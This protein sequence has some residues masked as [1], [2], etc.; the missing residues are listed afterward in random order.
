MLRTLLPRSGTARAAAV[1]AARGAPPSGPGD[2]LWSAQGPAGH[3]IA[4]ANG[5]QLGSR[6]R[7]LCG[8][9]GHSDFNDRLVE[10]SKKAGASGAA[11]A[12][13]AGNGGVKASVQG[14]VKGA[15]KAGAA[16]A[17]AAAA[18]AAATAK[19]TTVQGIAKG[20]KSSSST[21]SSSSSSSSN[22]TAVGSDSGS[23]GASPES[24]VEDALRTVLSAT[25]A[26]ASDV[27]GGCGTFYS[28]MVVSP[29]FEGLGRLKREMLANKFE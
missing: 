25:H 16:A 2:R 19:T 7:Q 8:S 10:K 28:I 3:V 18:A 14:I 5:G 6:R 15:A 22:S 12:A 13:D 17:T 23:A 21:S 29:E 26:E 24:Q 11:A 4:A 9:S 1:L 20:S 27:S